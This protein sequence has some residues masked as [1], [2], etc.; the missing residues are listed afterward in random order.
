MK[1]F[2]LLIAPS[3]QHDLWKKVSTN[4]TPLEFEQFKAAL[5]YIGY[6]FAK[7]KA[8]EIKYQLREL[9]FV[10]EYPN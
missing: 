5:P 8:R 10:L 6:E 2:D 4:Q 1:D 9:K 3:Q 7:A